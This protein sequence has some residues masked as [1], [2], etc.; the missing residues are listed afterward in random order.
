MHFQDLFACVEHNSRKMLP[1]NH[2]AGTSSSC[3]FVSRLE[4]LCSRFF[5]PS[6]ADNTKCKDTEM[7]EVQRQTHQASRRMTSMVDRNSLNRVQMDRCGRGL[8]AKAGAGKCVFLAVTSLL[9]LLLLS[10]LG[11]T[12]LLADLLPSFAVEIMPG[13][14]SFH[15][16]VTRSSVILSVYPSAASLCGVCALLHVFCLGIKREKPIAYWESVLG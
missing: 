14:Q 9:V 4:K 6:S 12:G 8:E 2:A 7:A 16:S 3:H 15:P 11:R 13:I 5:L 10:F 1:C